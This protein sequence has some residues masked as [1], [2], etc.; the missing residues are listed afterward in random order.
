MDYVK[1]EK[2]DGAIEECQR[3]LNAFL[4]GGHGQSL[5][6]DKPPLMFRYANGGTLPILN[7]KGETFYCLIYREV[8]PIGWNIANGGS[9]TSDEL[10]HPEEIMKRELREELIIIDSEAKTRFV[11]E[12]TIDHPEFLLVR[13]LI[14]VHF[15][16][17]RIQE[18]QEE[19]V[20][21][22]WLSGPDELVVSIERQ[23]PVRTSGCYV[24]INAIDLGIEI[25]R[26]MEI[27][28]GHWP[29]IM[30][31]EL[32]ESEPGKPR[33]VNAPVGL[34]KIDRLQAI[35]KERP[36]GPGKF[37]PDW[38]YWGGQRYEGAQTD[39]VVKTLFLPTM[40]KQ[41]GKAQLDY[42]WDTPDKYDLCPV[43]RNI[44]RR[45]T[46]C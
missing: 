25:D 33:L 19:S 44:I 20:D 12:K 9:D 38:I 37:E 4:I 40:E 15:P 31:G 16:D 45:I 7:I 22:T 18:L 39:Y 24:N 11:F 17:L 14:K 5:R 27:T 26:A 30:D 3:A 23:A 10:L 46:R 6:I 42:Y 36:E 29:Q 2:G 1:K 21:P 34:F 8:H 43:T 28:L 35:L 13:D 41:L 32:S